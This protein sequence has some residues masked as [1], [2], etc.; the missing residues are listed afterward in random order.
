VQA[1]RLL[2]SQGKTEEANA[3]YVDVKKKYVNSVVA[4]DIDKYIERTSK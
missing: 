1:A 4:M 3:I 2:E